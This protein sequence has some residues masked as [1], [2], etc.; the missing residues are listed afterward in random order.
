MKPIQQLA[1]EGRT[2][3][4]QRGLGVAKGKGKKIG[5]KEPVS[6]ASGGGLGVGWGR[7]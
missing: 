5:G 7:G 6:Q 1:R 4:R 3:T 2:G